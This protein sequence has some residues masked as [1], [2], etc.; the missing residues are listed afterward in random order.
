MRLAY[1]WGGNTTEEHLSLGEDASQPARDFG[2]EAGELA[3]ETQRRLKR[4]HIVAGF[5]SS[6]DHEDPYTVFSID[7]ATGNKVQLSP[8]ADTQLFRNLGVYLQ[9]QYRLMADKDWELALNARNDQ[10]NL[11]GNHNTYR[12]G[13]TGSLMP[14]LQFKLLHGTAFKAPNAFQLYAQPLFAGD[15]LGNAD[16]NVERANIT[17][18]QLL[19]HATEDVLASVTLYR[20]EVDD[21]IELQPLGINTRWDNRG[22]QSGHGLETELR[23]RLVEHDLGLTTSWHDTEATQETPLLPHQ[24]VATASAPRLLATADWRYHLPPLELGSRVHY[25]S[26][27]RASE[28]NIEANLRDP[29]SLGA[30][31]LWRL[32]STYTVGSHRLTTAID[33]AFDKDYTEPGYGGIDLPGERRTIWLNWAWSY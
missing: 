25:V 8:E 14:P 27:R 26:E 19:W 30:Y 12:L 21:L 16:L 32:Y 3:I 18:A 29:Y 9:I 33:N 28:D 10:H 17:E 7:R 2:Y 1:A 24:E 15:A 4:T 5:D 31:T 11:Y 20:L 22:R 6:W 13:V 23:W